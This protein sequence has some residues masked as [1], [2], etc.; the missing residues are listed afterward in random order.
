MKTLIRLLVLIAA[1]L[2]IWYL[3]A[4]RLT[5]FTNNARVKAVVT[6]LVPKVSGEVIEV[7]AGNGQWAEAGDLLARIDPV[8]YEIAR[9]KAQADLQS[10]IQEIGAGSAQVEAAQADLARATTELANTR[11]QVGRVFELEKK[12]L[13]AVARADDARATLADAESALVGARANLEQAR[14]Q[15]GPEGEDNPAIKRALATLSNAELQLS[16]TEIRAPGA[17]GVTNLDIAPG[18]F[19]TAAQP[20]MTFIDAENIWIEAYLTENNLGTMQAGNR[21]DVTLDIHPGR[22]LEGQVESFSVAASIGSDTADGLGAA[23]RSTG[24]MRDPQRFPV[25]IVLPGYARAD[26]GDDIRFNVNGQAEVIVYTGDTPL[27]NRLGAWY[28]RLKAYLSYAY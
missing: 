12:G 21:V 27:L 23:P 11:L 13:V 28:I 26:I 24:W 20:L 7:N 10:A 19:A 9:Q 25:R 4:D 6:Q 15:L 22:V 2:L 17:G 18:A 1:L 8:P 3:F 5:P 14:R 16:W